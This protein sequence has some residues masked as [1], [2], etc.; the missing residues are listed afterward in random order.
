MVIPITSEISMYQWWWL[1]VFCIPAISQLYLN[2]IPVNYIPITHWY[3][4]NIPIHKSLFLQNPYTIKKWSR[5]GNLHDSGHWRRWC[6]HPLWCMA[7]ECP[8]GRRQGR[9]NGFAEADF[10]G[11]SGGYHG[12]IWYTHILYTWIRY[13]YVHIHIDMHVYIYMYIYI[14]VYIYIYMYIYIYIYIYRSRTLWL[15]KWGD[16]QVHPKFFKIWGN[17]W[18]FHQEGRN[19]CCLSTCVAMSWYVLKDDDP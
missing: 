9:M 17:Q 19:T 2:Y 4:N 5:R 1:S 16:P 15:G 6:L 3:P 12:D 13:I 18:R 7:P 10:L 11:E 8:R 14:Y